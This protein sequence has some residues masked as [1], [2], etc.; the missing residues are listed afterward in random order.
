MRPLRPLLLISSLVILQATMFSSTA[1]AQ[2]VL[3]PGVF[4]TGVDGNGNSLPTNAS[5]THYIMSGGTS[6]ALGTSS[7]WIDPLGSSKWIGPTNGNVSAPFV[8]TVYTMTFDLTGYQ[9]NSATLTGMLASDT[10]V[11]VTLNGT[12]QSNN[13]CFY[14]LFTQQV[15]NSGFVA[16]VNTL[17]F[18]VLNTPTGGTNGS[19][20][21]FSN[22]TLKA[23]PDVT[24]VLV[25][26]NLVAGAQADLDVT[27]ATPGGAVVYGYSLAGTGPTPLGYTFCNGAVVL[28]LTAP[29]ELIGVATA[30]SLG[31]ATFS[32]TVPN[33]A[34][35]QVNIQA[36][37][38][39]TCIPTNVVTDTIQ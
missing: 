15:I 29:I 5:D 24:P 22:V 26:N 18:A 39:S 37:D 10:N 19:G 32:K 31:E 34:F 36:L 21:L 3:V 33:A 7:V 16:G 2:A 13:C 23:F 1:V 38:F 4:S 17:E 6:V 25:V 30:N 12:N 28:S 8:T 20:L 9:A 14:W 11:T 35:L 27:Q